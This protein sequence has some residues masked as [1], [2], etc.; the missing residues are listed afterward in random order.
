MADV[1]LF[2]CPSCG[3]TIEVENNLDTF[4]C[5]YCGHKI[6][7]DG[8]SDTLISAKVRMKELDYQERADKEYYKFEEKERKR[9]FI[10]K[11]SEGP[12][13]ALIYFGL[14]FLVIFVFYSIAVI[15]ENKEK[16]RLQKIVKEVNDLIDDRN[17]EEALRKANTIEYTESGDSS[18]KEWA[19]I[20][21]SLIERIEDTQEADF[22]ANSI[23]IPISSSSAK[24]KPY[25]D[26]EAQITAAGFTN[27]TCV[28]VNEKPSLFQDKGDIKSITVSGKTKFKSGAKFL[29]DV[30]IVI[31]YYSIEQ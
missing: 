12:F 21:K 31:N 11:L 8:Q 15:P 9:A 4:Y 6:L 27:V 28:S 29:P 25:Q 30:P 3:G 1:K 5:K 26:V 14:L 19:K 10:F 18:K 24:G 22:K 23:G 16:K 7:L 17:Y 13:G 20:R 2:N